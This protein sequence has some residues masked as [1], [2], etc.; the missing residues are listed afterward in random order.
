MFRIAV[1]AVVLLISGSA[2]AQQTASPEKLLEVINSLQQQRNAAEDNAA[3]WQTEARMAQKEIAKLREQI[4]KLAEQ[5]KPE[6]EPS[7]QK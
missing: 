3:N 1:I 4:Q 5:K 7:E 2:I 6:P